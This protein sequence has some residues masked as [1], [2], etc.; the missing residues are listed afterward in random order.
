MLELEV[1]VVIV[2]LGTETDLLDDHL[3]LIGLDLLGFLLLLVQEFLVVCDAADGGIGLGRN[4]DQVEFH[5]VGHAQCVAGGQHERL[6]DVVAH[7]AHLR[8]R[9]LVVD[10]MGILLLRRTART[11]RPGR[12]IS[13]PLITPRASGSRSEWTCRVYSSVLLI[14]LIKFAF[15]AVVFSPRHS[16]NKFGSALGLSKTFYFLILLASISAFT[17]PTM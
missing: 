13:V 15:D 14:W 12:T 4:L 10:A 9:D 5:L 3:H 7:Q 16:L 6:L 8:R 2:G 11:A 17:S 1:V